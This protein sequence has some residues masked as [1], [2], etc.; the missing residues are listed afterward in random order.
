VLT[1][2]FA[3]LYLRYTEPA[4]NASGQYTAPVIL[5]GALIGLNVGLAVSSAIVR[6]P[7]A[8]GTTPLT[9]TFATGR[10]C[11]HYLCR[12]GRRSVHSARTKSR[13]FRSKFIASIQ[14][15]SSD[16]FRS[17]AGDSTCLPASHPACWG[18]LRGFACFVPYNAPYNIRYCSVIR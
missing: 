9:T 13:S 12:A 16:S 3:Y 5:F 14:L 15:A 18:C 8:L 6:N 4:Y 10:R 17:Y 1:A 11:Q 7:Y 2:L